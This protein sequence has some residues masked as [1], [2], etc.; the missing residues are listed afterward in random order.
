MCGRYVSPEQAA[1]ERA[2]HI[3]RQNSN[4]FRRRYNVL[5]TTNVP[6]LRHAS[7]IGDTELTEARWGLIPHWWSRPKPPTS[8]INA[9]S[10]E[11]AGKPMWKDPYRR[12]RCL[13]PAAGWYEW[14][15]L[16]RT[17]PETG[18]VTTYKQP[19]YLWVE[20]ADTVCF[21]GLMSTWNTQMGQPQVTCAILTRAPSASAA[22]VHDRMP[23]ILSPAAFGAWLDPALQD[24]NQ[25]AEVI[26]R[27]AIDEVRHHRVD[28][29][30][31]ASK[32]D[33]AGLITP[34][35]S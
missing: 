22:V 26:R 1:I 28:T 5:P 21:A 29:R 11:A 9:R 33:D 35:R 24:A 18:E 4:P 20:G 7:D 3:G 31:N 15:Q 23:V 19:F 2:Y 8:T 16:E 27:H 6:I 10:E 34:I 14:Q 12:S 25:V 13:I 32:T 17:D 30:L